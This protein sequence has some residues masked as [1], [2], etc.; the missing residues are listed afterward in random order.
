MDQQRPHVRL[1]ARQRERGGPPVRIAAA[2][3]RL[4]QRLG[5]R[6]LGARGQGQARRF[7]VAE[8]EQPGIPETTIL[9]RYAGPDLFRVQIETPQNFQN[10]A[11]EPSWRLRIVL[12]PVGPHHETAPAIR[13]MDRHLVDNRVLGDRHGTGRVR[14]AMH[15]GARTH[16]HRPRQVALDYQRTLAKF[17]SRRQDAV[18]H[19]ALEQPAEVGSRTDVRERAVHQRAV[20]RDPVQQGGQAGQRARRFP[21]ER[22][23]ELLIEVEGRNL[24]QGGSQMRQAGGQPCVEVEEARIEC[25]LVAGED[26]TGS[27]H[28]GGSGLLQEGIHP[29]ALVEDIDAMARADFNR[30]PDSGAGY[31]GTV[32]VEIRCVERQNDIAGRHHHTGREPLQPERGESHGLVEDGAVLAPGRAHGQ[33]AEQLAD[34]TVLGQAAGLAAGVDDEDPV[35]A[36]PRRIVPV[37]GLEGAERRSAAA[38]VAASRIGDSVPGDA[39]RQGAALRAL[40]DLLA[41]KP[42]LGIGPGRDDD[43]GPPTGR[44]R[45]FRENLKESPVGALADV[46]PLDDVANRNLHFGLPGSVQYTPGHLRS[47]FGSASRQSP[48]GPSSRLFWS[49]T[50]AASPPPRSPAP[51]P[52]R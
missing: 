7:V 49:S 43:S 23:R 48:E 6:V 38:D 29:A 39:A 26:S 4:G 20:E 3:P 14:Q 28:L 21:G 32:P 2:V 46:A 12:H 8:Q 51:R 40:A 10:R 31:S 27:A 11:A 52:S 36:P 25:D 45:G 9:P 16:A 19:S 30:L 42:G 24:V 37:Q 22:E 1:R 17:G 18:H 34:E 35:A 33:D 41:I 44:G 50:G 15:D 13:Q 47:R 5:I